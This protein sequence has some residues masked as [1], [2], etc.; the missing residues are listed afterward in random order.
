MRLGSLWVQ[1]GAKNPKHSPW[2]IFLTR[3]LQ[4]L[5]TVAQSDPIGSQRFHAEPGSEPRPVLLPN[6]NLPTPG[7]LS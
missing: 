5:G 4:L 3:V 6:P 7:W 1:H 2:V